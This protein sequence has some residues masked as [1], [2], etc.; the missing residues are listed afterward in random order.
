MLNDATNLA[1]MSTDTSPVCI[2][3]VTKKSLVLIQRGSRLK[4]LLKRKYDLFQSYGYPAAAVTLMYEARLVLYTNMMRSVRFLVHSMKIPP[5]PC[6][7]SKWY[8]LFD[9]T[10]L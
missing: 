5:L 3:G 1:S 4:V 6:L 8:T 9:K 2:A 7:F 10:I